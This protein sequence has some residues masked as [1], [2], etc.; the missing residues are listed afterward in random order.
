MTRI[1][2][3]GNSLSN[4]LS[5]RMPVAL[6]AQKAGYEVHVALPE[7]D[8]PN[9]VTA[10]FHYH[11]FSLSRRGINPLMEIFSIFSIWRLLQKIKPDLLFCITIKPILYGGLL[12]RW[13]KVTGVVSVMTG[14]GF[15]FI[16]PGMLGKV[17]RFLIRPFYRFVFSYSK[18][19]VIFQNK[20]DLSYFLETGL[21]PREKAF[22]IP[23]SGVDVDSFVAIDFSD[24][25]PCVILPARMLWDKGVGEFVDAARL[26]KKKGVKARFVLVGAPDP[27][28]PASIH[29]DQIDIWVKEG[30]VEYW[31]HQDDM[32]K[33][34]AQSHIVCLPSYREGLPRVL[35]EAMACGRP[36]VTTDV[37]GCRD[38]VKDGVTG[39]LVPDRQYVALAEGLMVMLESKDQW[40][41]MGQVAR[42]WVENEF[43]DIRV[44]SQTRKVYEKLI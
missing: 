15:V 24:A 32:R 43:S 41:W 10:G 11:S 37:P 13:M 35:L 17:S 27:G 3:L 14:L 25:V 33:V 9:L 21:L 36:V 29:S 6:D 34:Y 31:G 4:F 28:N 44:A 22:L 7:K 5:H 42:E 40:R 16:H 1:L 39:F 23:G 8:A 2:F 12:A 20:S 30:A 18:S 38:V 26:L 19:R